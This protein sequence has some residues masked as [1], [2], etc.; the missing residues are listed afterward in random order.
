MVPNIAHTSI[1]GKCTSW[2]DCAIAQEHIIFIHRSSS[3]F[4]SQLFSTHD[5]MSQNFYVDLL[6]SYRSTTKNDAFRYASSVLEAE[7]LSSGDH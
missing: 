3:K 2:L 6:R 1:L 4:D 5:T 7:P